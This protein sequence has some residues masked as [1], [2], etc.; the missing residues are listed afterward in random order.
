MQSFATPGA[1]AA[2]EGSNPAFSPQQPVGSM[3]GQESVA[4]EGPY[5]DT[6][7]NQL[8]QPLDVGSAD[9]MERTASIGQMFNPDLI[10]SFPSP[11]S[12]Y[13]QPTESIR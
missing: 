12:G 4:M 3:D 13:E 11:G 2:M 7:S 1:L 6:G 8:M 10:T 5:I 9:E